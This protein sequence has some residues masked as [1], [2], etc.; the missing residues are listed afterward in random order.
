ME[1]KFIRVLATLGIPGVALGIFYLLLRAFN[2]QFSQ[3][4]AAWTAAIVIIFL[5][6]VGG[7][8]IFALHKWA[9]I[10]PQQ[11]RAEWP[12]PVGQNQNNS[13]PESEIRE[14]D[15]ISTLTVRDIIEEI[16]KASPFQR[17]TIE[18]N[19]CGIKVNLRGTLWSVEKPF[20]VTKGDRVKVVLHEEGTRFQYGIIFEVSISKYPQFKV[21]RRG[22]VIGVLGRIV[23]CSGVGVY[24]EVGVDD[25]KFHGSA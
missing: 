2:F 22:E 9:P 16:H 6:I 7:I 23:G 5:L 13:E 24:V 19:Y 21:A 1:T 17:D 8:T 20:G 11:L 15:Q 12:Q 3:V 4:D 18:K 25:I 10:R 14:S